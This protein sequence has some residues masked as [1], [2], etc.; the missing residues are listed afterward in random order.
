MNNNNNNNIRATFNYILVVATVVMCI[1]KYIGGYNIPAI[2]VFAP[3][4][5]ITAINLFKLIFIVLPV[6]IVK[7]GT[8]HKATKKW[9][10]NFYS[11]SACGKRIYWN[12]KTKEMEGVE[13]MPE[14]NKWKDEE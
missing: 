12:P 5:A 3:V 9:R 4:I 2:I 10:N 11:S 7:M 8:E 14:Y 1:I 13:P 6:L